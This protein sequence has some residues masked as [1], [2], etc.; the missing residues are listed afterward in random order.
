M[1]LAMLR[2]RVAGADDPGAALHQR[3]FSDLSRVALMGGGG[4]PKVQRGWAVVSKREQ[5][6]PKIP[7]VSHFCDVCAAFRLRAFRSG[8]CFVPTGGVGM[9]YGLLFLGR[10]NVVFFCLV[11]RSFHALGEKVRIHRREELLASVEVAY[12]LA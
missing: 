9:R 3:Q 7:G 4:S 10:F 1:S 11:L 12:S 2:G 6:R 5:F 8:R